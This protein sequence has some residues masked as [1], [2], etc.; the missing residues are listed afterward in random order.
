LVVEVSR[1]LERTP[2]SISLRGQSLLQPLL[3]LAGAMFEHEFEGD[4]FEKQVL[5]SRE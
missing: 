3:Q 4:V 1:N 2:A 5:Q